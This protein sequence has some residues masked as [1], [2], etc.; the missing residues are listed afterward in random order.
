MA[1]HKDDLPQSLTP[2]EKFKSFFAAYF[3]VYNSEPD[4]TSDKYREFVI[5]MQLISLTDGVDAFNK[6][7]RT[8]NNKLTEEE[9]SDAKK[10]EEYLNQK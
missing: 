8:V 5:A 4:F 1:I 9:I 3:K 10:W 7:Y 6:V 2:V